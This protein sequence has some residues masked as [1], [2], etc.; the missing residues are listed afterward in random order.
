[1][2][3]VSAIVAGSA[4]FRLSAVRRLLHERL[5]K[6]E[7]RVV[8]YSFPMKL[9]HSLFHVGASRLTQLPRFTGYYAFYAC[10]VLMDLILPVRLLLIA[11]R[12]PSAGN[13]IDL[14]M[15]VYQIE[16]TLVE[17]LRPH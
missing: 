10:P 1:M 15:A 5:P 6:L 3:F 12:C 2:V 14:K 11:E 9:F 17:L 4:T 16:G 7:V 8:R 13:I